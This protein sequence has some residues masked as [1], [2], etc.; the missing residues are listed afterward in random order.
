[1]LCS[2]A[3]WLC[4]NY[5]R[6]LFYCF[7]FCCSLE[8]SSE[9]GNWEV[10]KCAPFEFSRGN[11]SHTT[12]SNWNQHE[13]KTKI[14]I[15]CYQSKC[16]DLV[17]PLYVQDTQGTYTLH[18]CCSLKKYFNL[19][20]LQAMAGSFLFIY[21]AN[22]NAISRCKQI[23][24][25]C[26][27]LKKYHLWSTFLGGELSTR[28]K[29]LSINK[30]WAVWAQNFICGKD[31]R[32]FKVKCL[33]FLGWHTVYVRRGLTLPLN[34]SH[35]FLTTAAHHTIHPS[36]PFTPH[37]K[38][39]QCAVLLHTLM[40]H[41][42]CGNTTLQQHHT[43]VTWFMQQHH[44]IH[45]ATPHDPCSNTTW[46][47]QQN[48]MIHAAT[49]HDSCSNTT[50]F[51]RQHH[52]IHAA[53]PHDSCSNT[54]WSMQQHHMIHAA[55]P[56]DSCSNTT[57]FMQ[58][59][60]MMHAATPHDACSNTTWFMRQHHINHAATPHDACSNTTWFMRQHHMI[61]AATPH[62]SCSNTT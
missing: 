19:D 9:G 7:S 51:M 44:M 23:I 10:P 25:L 41:D 26:T 35:I 45:A 34:M 38:M 13:H 46:S 61:H 42:S 59:H 4:H 56:H 18:C 32:N 60:H 49:P 20:N 15:K 57:W 40:S 3:G 27:I 22:Q 6:S 53:T 47:M 37:Y 48:H 24:R 58:Q 39:R 12:S 2:A 14:D 36:Y 17:K 33:L 31:D 30:N 28:P 43:H 54:T 8:E 52:M 55:T 29:R 62:D 1:M 5:Q 21:F 11:C 16:S 50:W